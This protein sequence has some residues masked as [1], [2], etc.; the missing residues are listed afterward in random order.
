MTNSEANKVIIP[1]NG[2]TTTM[3][4]V[5]TSVGRV[6]TNGVGMFIGD[7]GTESSSD[8]GLYA[9][10]ESGNG[11][12]NTFKLL[13]N[14]NFSA[15]GDITLTNSSFTPTTI[16]AANIPVYLKNGKIVRTMNNIKTSGGNNVSLADLAQAIINLKTILSDMSLTTA[17]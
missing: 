8:Y 2:I 11:V 10:K 6:L 17:Q 15:T 13:A 1:E 9:F 3:Q 5:N 16:G 7:Y 12:D 14:G 4:I